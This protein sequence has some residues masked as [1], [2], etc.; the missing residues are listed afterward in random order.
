MKVSTVFRDKVVI[1]AGGASG[2]GEQ[3]VKQLQPITKTIIILDRNKAAGEAL[4][5]VYR[6]VDFETV[7]MTNG[8]EVKHTIRS[9]AK[10]QTIDYFFNFAGTFLAGEMRDTPLEDWQAIYDSNIK[11]ILHGTEAIYEVMRTQ[12]TGHIIN[13]ASAAGLFPVPVM[14]IYGS[15][16]AAVISLSLGLAMEAKTFGIAT[17]VVCPTIVETPLYD[18][19]RYDGV[20]KP[21]AV[22]LLKDRL[23]I[24]QPDIAAQRIL[25]GVAR[26]RTIIHTS[27]A[28]RLTAFAFKTLTR[29]YLSVAS[30]IFPTYRSSYRL[31]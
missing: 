12:Q 31:K 24:Q 30:R 21:K 2:I 7:E 26:N 9:L 19:A 22:K 15:T 18:T 23:K 5:R 4:A 14:N 27:G 17:S 28:T 10:K 16:K 11:P 8:A 6:N 20:D 1:V 25:K 3:V 13:V 29:P